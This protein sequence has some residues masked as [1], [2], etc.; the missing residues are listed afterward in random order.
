M[1]KA[2]L[3]SQ[4]VDTTKLTLKNARELLELEFV[5]FL[6]L[7]RFGTRPGLS[8]LRNPSAK[9]DDRWVSLRGWAR[10]RS[11]LEHVEDNSFSW[12]ALS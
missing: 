10:I 2:D 11:P 7:S 4:S 5:P 6:S 12:L 3:G 9:D 8:S 1:R